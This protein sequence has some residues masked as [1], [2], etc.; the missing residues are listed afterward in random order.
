MLLRR[1]SGVRGVGA[2]VAVVVEREAPAEVV[3]MFPPGKK[4]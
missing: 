2:A 3:D 4:L 1:A